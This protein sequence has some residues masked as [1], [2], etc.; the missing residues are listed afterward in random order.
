MARN[1]ETKIELTAYDDLFQTDESR[2]EAKLSKI[3]DIPISEI[4]EFPDHP[5]KVLMDEDIMTVGNIP[6]YSCRRCLSM[7]R[8]CSSRIIEFFSRPSKSFIK[9]CVGSFAFVCTRLV[10]GATITVGLCLFPIS[11]EMIS[12]GLVPPCSEP[13]TGL[14][15]A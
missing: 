13:I 11:L 6:I 9:V 5:F 4:D 10:I 2:E 12:T 8:I 1:R 15:S 7:V 14:S 3:R